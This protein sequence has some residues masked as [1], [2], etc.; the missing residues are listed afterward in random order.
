MFAL[1]S[2]APADVTREKKGEDEQEAAK[3][4]K[5]PY[6]KSECALVGEERIW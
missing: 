6:Y 3:R 5:N 4:A 1:G 2:G